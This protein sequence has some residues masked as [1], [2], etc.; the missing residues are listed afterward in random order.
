MANTTFKGD[1]VDTVGSLPAVGAPPPAFSLTQADLSELESASLAG[2]HVI[3]N[4][5]PSIDTSVCAASVRRFNVEGAAL[6]NA[7]VVCVSV[8]LPFALKRFCAAE[9]ISGV[10]TASAFRSTFGSDYG[11]LIAGGI[12]RGLLA[13]AVVVIGGNGTV[14]HVELVPDIA[15]EPDYAKALA[16][17]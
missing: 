11:V 2:K 17:V 6:T 4:I 1:R 14:T 3:L 7:V 13:R 15:K 8:D 16:A 12:F 10:R 5:F 9:G